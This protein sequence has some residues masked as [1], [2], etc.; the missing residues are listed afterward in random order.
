MA[1]PEN[2]NNPS[3]EHFLAWEDELPRTVR[4]GMLDRRSFM[5]T[6]HEVETDTTEDT[7]LA[8]LVEL[9]RLDVRPGGYSFHSLPLEDNFLRVGITPPP[10]FKQYDP[11]GNLYRITLNYVGSD[12]QNLSGRRF[13]IIDSIVSPAAWSVTWREAAVSYPAGVHTYNLPPCTPPVISRGK[14]GGYRLYESSGYVMWPPP[15]YD[16]DRDTYQVQMN[17]QLAQELATALG[18]L[19]VGVT[20]EL[21]EANI[22]DNPEA[23]V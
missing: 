17:R 15:H 2:P 21:A 18:S 4:T 23:E 16:Y 9:E 22:R 19:S 5:K 7:F 3:L 12:P 8:L 6:L 10:K 20:Q 13:R 1:I 11:I 14:R